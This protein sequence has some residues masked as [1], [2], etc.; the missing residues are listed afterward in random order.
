MKTITQLSHEL[1]I[2]IKELRQTLLNKNVIQKMNNGYELTDAGKEY[3]Q[4]HYFSNK[5]K[6]VKFI[7]YNSTIIDLVNSDIAL[8][9]N[10]QELP[11]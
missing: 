1:S 10:C 9:P 11:F 6:S 7:K 5:G 4:Y 2:Q 3:G 8:Q